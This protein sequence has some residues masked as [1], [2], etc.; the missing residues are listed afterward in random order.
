MKKYMLLLAGLVLIFNAQ[1]D[2]IIA[3]KPQD[4]LSGDNKA[5]ALYGNSYTHYN[6]NVNTR[7]RDLSRSLLP[8]EAKGYMFRGITISSGRLGWH[9]PNLE[10]Q[11]TLQKW[12]VVIFQ[13]NSTEPFAAKEDSR[14]YFTESAVKMADIAHKEGSRVVY[15]MTWARKDNPGETAKLEEAYLDIASKTGGYVA[16]VG[17]AFRNAMKAYPE[18]NLYHSDGNH[19]SLAGTYLAACVLF[20]TLYD[21][22]P[23]GGALPVDS[24]MTVQ[25]AKALQQ[26]AWDTVTKFRAN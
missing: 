24:D 5:V 3:T 4:K 21:H 11:N 7:L 15:F 8:D 26:V 18:I 25:T 23:I 19:P 1:A 6:N 10:F 12:D 22:S 14:Q 9:L 16:P 17:Q 13:G 2:T 20:A